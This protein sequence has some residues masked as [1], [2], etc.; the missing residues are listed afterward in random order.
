MSELAR[1]IPM[2]AELSD[3]LGAMIETSVLLQ[4][5]AGMSLD[6]FGKHA[7]DRRGTLSLELTGEH[8]AYKIFS[9]GGWLFVTACPLDLGVWQ[10]LL[11]APD[12]H[13]GRERV[14]AAIIAIE[15]SG[16]NSV[17]KDVV[18]TILGTNG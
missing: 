3:R 5:E 1:A 4:E 14:R 7:T 18:D 15:S 11:V 17:N 9:D 2:S 10:E 13:L 6:F 12:G 16:I 8:L